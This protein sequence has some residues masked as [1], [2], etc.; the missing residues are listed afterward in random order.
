MIPMERLKLYIDG[1]WIESESQQSIDIV[2]PESQKVIARIPRSNEADV[3]KAAAA[4]K[5]AFAS[6]Q[7][8]PLK[9]RLE[10]MER[11]VRSMKENR[12]RF[13]E[14][15]SAELGCPVKVAAEVHTDPFILEGGKLYRNRP[16]LLLRGS[17]GDL[18]GSPGSRWAWWPD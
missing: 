8:T 9:T 17:P 2:N 12:S 7:F 10:L 5:R 18:G 6:W 4:A 1:R 16:E 14:T 15:I 13:I 3:N 11:V